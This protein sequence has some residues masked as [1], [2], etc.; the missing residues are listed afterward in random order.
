MRNRIQPL[1]AL[2]LTLSGLSGCVY[3]TRAEYDEFFDKDGD[4]WS[5]DEDCDDDN[6]DVYPFAPDRRGDG[7]DADCGEELDSD[8][9]DWPDKADC[10]PKDPNSFPCSPFEVNL[11]GVDN[12][13]DG[14]DDVRIDTCPTADPDNEDA[15][16]L[17]C[18]GGEGE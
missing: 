16:I 7:C 1:L 3:V 14:L 4:G 10:E 9:D 8:G 17:E 15:P 11:D 5:L 18:A 12:D 13:C 6:P 2:C